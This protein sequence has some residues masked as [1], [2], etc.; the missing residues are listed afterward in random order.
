[1]ALSLPTERKQRPVGTV[2]NRAGSCITDFDVN[3]LSSALNDLEGPGQAFL[4]ENLWYSSPPLDQHH[5]AQKGR[6][7]VSPPEIVTDVEAWSPNISL[8]F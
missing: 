7:S 3:T 6:W 5:W 1:M 4:K 2:E 8:A